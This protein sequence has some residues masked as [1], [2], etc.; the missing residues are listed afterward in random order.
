MPPAQ[1]APKL[2]YLALIMA[3]PL[4]FIT[5]GLDL[6]DS[7]YYAFNY[8]YAFSWPEAATLT[9]VFSHWLGGLISAGLPETGLFLSLKVIGVGLYALITWFSWLILRGHF[10]A[11]LNLPAL[12][13][14]NLCP[15]ALVYTAG[16]DSFS[17]FF[18]A[19]ALLLLYRG[20]E[21][22]RPRLLYGAAALL[23]LNVFVNLPNILGW[24]LVA[25]PFWY[26]WFG[27]GQRRRAL[28]VTRRFLMT[29]LG[30]WEVGWGLV[31]LALGPELIWPQ[32]DGLI[33]SFFLSYGWNSAFALW[34]AY[35]LI[36]RTSGPLLIRTV[37]PLGLLALALAGG[38][39]AAGRRWWLAAPLAA[40]GLVAGPA[41]ALW[42]GQVYYVPLFKNVAWSRPLTSLCLFLAL[43]GPALALAGAL[44]HHQRRPLLSALAVMVIVIFLA[45]PFAGDYGATHYLYY[46]HLALPVVIGLTHRLWLEGITWLKGLAWLKGAPRLDGLRPSP[47]A[48]DLRPALVAANALLWFLLAGG[49]RTIG[50]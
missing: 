42:G 40:L 47:S 39:M 25:G 5:R 16:P 41:L 36:L 11:R 7:A 33:D 32:I 22:G 35:D 50:L 43:A 29:L 8:R 4:L 49:F 14:A 18:M 21:R 19:A 17:Y 37:L 12:A 24:G 45:L 20:L 2:K 6:T 10:P 1:L 9:Q 44:W 46:L 13:L 38:I 28:T 15:T 30:V 3:G 26:Y 34:D 23:A 27:L 31:W 48:L